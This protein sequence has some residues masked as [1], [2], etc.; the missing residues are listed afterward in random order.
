MLVPGLP[1]LDAHVHATI[2][3]EDVDRVLRELASMRRDGLERLLVYLPVRERDRDEYRRV[4]AALPVPALQGYV[5]D[6]YID[7]A[8][9]LA[10]VQDRLGPEHPKIDVVPQVDVVDDQVRSV[11]LDAVERG[12][13][14]VKFVHEDF[15]GGVAIASMR[16]GQWELLEALAARS[17]P[18][19]MHVDLRRFGDFVDECLRIVPRLRLTLAH[20]G[21]SRRLVADYLERGDV[22]ADIANLG[23][24]IVERSHSYA[25]FLEAYSESIVFGSDAFLGD[26]RGIA[27]HADAISKIGLSDEAV[28]RLMAGTWPPDQA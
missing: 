19:I 24:H 26:L 7:D 12:A 16:E 5:R 23:A 28:G 25:P 11:V 27:D 2:R 10:A 14:A 21:Y 20:L 17:T 8:A 4:V 3:L 9:G 15:D 18:V 13:P 6:E 22:T 1:R